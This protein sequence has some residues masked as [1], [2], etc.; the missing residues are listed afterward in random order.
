MNPQCDI[1]IVGLAVMGQNL[2]LNMADHGFEVAAY[3]R[4]TQ[5]VDEFM[6]GAARSKSI[7]GCRNPE[8][9]LRNLKRPRRVMLMVSLREGDIENDVQ[10]RSIYS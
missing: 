9:L 7:F 4:T 10:L 5:K 3:N 1:G 2:I 8:E 6:A